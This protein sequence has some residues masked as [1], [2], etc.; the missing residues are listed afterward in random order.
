MNNVAH[1]LFTVILF[2]VIS[3]CSVKEDRTPCPTYITMDATAFL[4]YTDTV[5]VHMLSETQSIRDTLDLEAGQMS[6]EW[7]AQKGKII[8]YA[9]SNIKRSVEKNGIVT[10]PVGEQADPL[11]AFSRRF[12][13]YDEL[14]SVE[15]QAP[16]QSALIH[17]RFNNVDEPVYPYDL[18]VVGDVCGIDLKSLTPYGGE[19]RYS[20]PLDKD[21]CCEFY[22]PRQFSDSKPVIELSY[23][24]EHI[25]TLPLYSWLRSAEYD[26]DSDDLPDVYIDIEQGQL[27]VDIRVEDW[28][29]DGNY[30]VIF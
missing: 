5:Y 18:V 2:T 26:W 20:L 12:E 21:N 9:F 11:R 13:S 28:S 30:D 29:F 15:A 7:A 16:R 14:V 8:T 22:L 27:H 25:D 10:I 1:I 4:K 6:A 3:S 19:F 24:G 23:L 17:L